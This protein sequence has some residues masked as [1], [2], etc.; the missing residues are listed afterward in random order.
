MTTVQI[1]ALSYNSVVSSAEIGLAIEGIYAAHPPAYTRL[2]PQSVSGD[3]A[4]GERAAIHDPLWLLFRQWQFSEFRGEDN[5]RILGTSVR[6][7]TR[8]LASLTA[9][10]GGAR[11]IGDATLLDPEIEAGA[12]TPPSPRA[13]AE[14]G[15][16]LVVA[17]AGAGQANLDLAKLY[18]FSDADVDATPSALRPILRANPDARVAATALSGAPPPWAPPG[19]AVAAAVAEWLGWYRASVDPASTSGGWDRAR[20][21]YAFQ[22]EVAGGQ[23]LRAEEHAGGAVDWWNVDAGAQANKAAAA[24][25]KGEAK[26]LAQPLRFP[27]MPADRYFEFEDGSVNLGG[28]DIE[29]NDPAR[30]ALIEF[31]TIHGPDWFYV[32]VEVP[33]GGLTTIEELTVTDTFA[34][35][36]VIPPASPGEG[37]A[38]FRLF[39]VTAGDGVLPGLLT[40]PAA[41]A[42]LDGEPLEATVL[43][44]DEGANMG[45]AIEERV[46]GSAGRARLRFSEARPAIGI[47][48]AGPADADLGYTLETEVPL[49]WIPLVPVPKG[50]AGGFVLR[51]GTMTDKDESRSRLLA[52]ESVDI[53]DEELPSAGLRI[54]R[55]P[56]LAR[57]PDGRLRRWVAFQVRA[58]SGPVSSGLAYDAAVP[59]GA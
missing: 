18:P 10:S 54:E 37:D 52:G 13:R 28:I 40:L 47:A 31:A 24:V 27:A 50:G 41:H 25:E 6:W 8:P 30:R 15:R 12:A 44:R 19:S 49:N 46:E 39:A 53:F 21:E 17:L 7:S 4:P 1:G 56:R 9:G 11:P 59:R 36:T 43:L 38:K 34:V 29:P 26:L 51:K 2:E 3:P 45:W 35:K 16:A 22:V 58:A 23:T 57:G 48:A 14:A 33:R 5:G 55:V 42:T 32:P 20:L